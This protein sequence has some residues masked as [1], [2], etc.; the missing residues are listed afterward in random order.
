METFHHLYKIFCFGSPDNFCYE[1]RKR[2]IKSFDVF[3]QNVKTNAVLKKKLTPHFNYGGK[4]STF[5][6]LIFSFLSLLISRRKA[7]AKA[8]QAKPA[9][10]KP[11]VHQ[12]AHLS[13]NQNRRRKSLNHDPR[14]M[15]YPQ[16]LSSMLT[17]SV[18]T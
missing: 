15:F 9:K 6:E 1:K 5:S 3:Q 11:V 12:V 8:K 7:K 18:M 4:T 2:N 13:E 14:S 17:I 16:L 10:R